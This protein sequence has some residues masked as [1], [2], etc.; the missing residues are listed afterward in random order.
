MSL[1]IPMEQTTL[2]IASPSKD[3]KDRKHLFIILTNPK[4]EGQYVL[5]VSIS[6]LRSD[7]YC[8]PTCILSAGEHDFIK[9]DSFVA[10][11]LAKI[12]ESEKLMEGVK[13][14][15]IK[16]KGLIEAG[17]F[18]RICIGLGESQH[19]PLKIKKFMESNQP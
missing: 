11:S 12:I 13:K 15:V 19:T 9:H 14:G 10:Y 2:L 16:Y 1:F 3:D 5:M 4:G 8:D 7:R 18:E 17:V 6:T